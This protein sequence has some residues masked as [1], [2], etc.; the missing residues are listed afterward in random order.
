MS[1]ISVD[2][3]DDNSDITL[4]KSYRPYMRGLLKS[5]KIHLPSNENNHKLSTLRFK[6]FDLFEKKKSKMTSGI[7]VV[8]FYFFNS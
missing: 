8:Y 7:L 4:K 3:G 1:V 2:N 5:L 6:I